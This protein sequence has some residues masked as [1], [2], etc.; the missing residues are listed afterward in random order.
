LGAKEVEEGRVFRRSEIS[1]ERRMAFEA[2]AKRRRRRR[3]RGLARLTTR[4]A[5]FPSTT[6]EFNWYLSTNGS[7]LLSNC[8][9][10]SHF[11]LIV[12]ELDS[13]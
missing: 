8:S 4:M 11:L 6:L 1:E 13:R 2:A 3:R 9:S 5:R 10:G 7:P 12:R